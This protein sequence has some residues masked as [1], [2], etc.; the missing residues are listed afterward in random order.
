MRW[1]ARWRVVP[2][3]STS[4]VVMH[5]EVEFSVPTETALSEAERGC[6]N[7]LSGLTGT[8]PGAILEAIAEQRWTGDMPRPEERSR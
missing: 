8:S 6:V 1:Q 7:L 2:D 3:G 5:V 4:I